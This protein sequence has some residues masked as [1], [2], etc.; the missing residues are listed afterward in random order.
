MPGSTATKPQSLIFTPLKTGIKFS[1]RDPT[2]QTAGT[3]SKASFARIFWEL[4]RAPDNVEFR[5][6]D[7][8]LTHFACTRDELSKNGNLEDVSN[9]SKYW[10]T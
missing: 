6:D 10:D 4:E 1:C 9:T 8:S 7:V 2:S 3:L 5:V